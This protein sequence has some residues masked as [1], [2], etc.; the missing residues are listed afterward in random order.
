MNRP[1]RPAKIIDVMDPVPTEVMM[2][3]TM[4]KLEA[5]GVTAERVIETLLAN[6]IERESSC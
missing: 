5:A 2:S 4:T 3:G 6:P 1:T